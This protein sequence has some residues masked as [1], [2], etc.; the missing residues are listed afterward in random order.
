MDFPA[1]ADMKKIL[2]AVDGNSLMH[3]AF[4]ALPL[5]TRK[6]GTY[7]NAVFG[8]FSMLVNAISVHRPD[9]LAIAFDK[10]GKTFGTI[11]SMRTRENASR[12]LLSLFR[13]SI[14]LNPR[15]AT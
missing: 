7:T 2:M 9:Y 13:S 3:R 12:R 10:K 15:F 1:G 4:Y 8:F 14:R 5:L 11:Y 6:D